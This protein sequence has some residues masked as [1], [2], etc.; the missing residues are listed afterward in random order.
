MNIEI[1]MRI[2]IFLCFFFVFFLIFLRLSKIHEGHPRFMRRFFPV[3]LLL[4]PMAVVQ[5]FND[6]N[7]FMNTGVL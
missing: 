3:W 7:G 2:K 6:F 5:Y 4:A 1:S